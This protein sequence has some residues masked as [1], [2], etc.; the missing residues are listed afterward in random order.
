[1]YLREQERAKRNASIALGLRESAS[2]SWNACAE[3]SR[4]LL[5]LRTDPEFRRLVGSH[6][7]LLDVL[8]ASLVAAM[9][10]D[11]A[12]AVLNLVVAR[13]ALRPLLVRVEVLG[14][15]AYAYPEE[16]VILLEIVSG[17]HKRAVSADMKTEAG[18]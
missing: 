13:A 7:G 12:D 16:L 15:L 17:C 18:A 8:P 10:H 4:A 1:M 3:V 9:P 14:W 5:T 2:K 11:R 6:H